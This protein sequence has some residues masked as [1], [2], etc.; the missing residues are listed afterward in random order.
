MGRRPNRSDSGP[1]ISCEVPKASSS[2]L[3]VRCACDIGAPKP[4]VSAGRAGR[5]KSVVTGWMP[6]S[7]DR[8][9]T[10]RLGDMLVGAAAV[11]A[12]EIVGVDGVEAGI[13]LRLSDCP[14]QRGTRGTPAGQPRVLTNQGWRKSSAP[15]QEQ[16]IKLTDAHLSPGGSSMVALV[17]ALGLFHLPQQGIHFI[18]RELAVGAHGTVAG[19]GREQLVLCPLD[20]GA[21]FVLGQLGQYAAGEVHGVALCQAGGHGTDGEGSW[22]KRRDLQA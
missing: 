17:G 1:Q 20:D 6:S 10:I 7:I 19:H 12:R 3:N 15:A 2:A 16:R 13:R 21:G 18:E 8:I 22:G 14:P 11:I 9:S 5:Y 4:S